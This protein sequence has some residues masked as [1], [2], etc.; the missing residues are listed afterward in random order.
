MP[1]LQHDFPTSNKWFPLTDTV[2]QRNGRLVLAKLSD[3]LD[4]VRGFADDA[5]QRLH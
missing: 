3:G 5:M 1:T 4:A 2:D